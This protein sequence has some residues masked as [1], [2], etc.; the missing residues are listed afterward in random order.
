MPHSQDLL[1]LLVHLGTLPTSLA[2]L[3]L[4]LGL[5]PD[6]NEGPAHSVERIMGLEGSR[7][8]ATSQ[9]SAGCWLSWCLGLAGPGC[10][11]AQL[12]LSSLAPQK[13]AKAYHASESPESP[14]D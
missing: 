3:L 2:L 4:L 6:V 7:Q 9:V 1:G 14:D 13:E 8:Q 11:P 12:M 10:L 5:M